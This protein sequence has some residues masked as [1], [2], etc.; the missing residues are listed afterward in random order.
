MKRIFF[1][2]KLTPQINYGEHF[3]KRQQTRTTTTTTTTTLTR[4]KRTTNLHHYTTFTKPGFIIFTPTLA[5]C[6]NNHRRRA[7]QS[8]EP[9]H[10]QRLWGGGALQQKP[11][12]AR[13]WCCCTRSIDLVIF[14]TWKTWNLWIEYIHP[15]ENWHFHWKRDHVFKRK[16]YFPTINFWMIWYVSFQ[17]GFIPICILWKDTPHPM[18]L[19]PT[20]TL[21]WFWCVYLTCPEDVNMYLVFFIY[22]YCVSMCGFV[23]TSKWLSG[24]PIH[25][26]CICSLFTRHRYLYIVV[27]LKCSLACSNN[28]QPQELYKA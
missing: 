4:T 25:M 6:W 8:F 20:Y 2:G 24:L 7:E 16:C 15:C 21:F 5:P 10:V 23:R 12:D 19:H 26:I 1:G 28:F 13:M 11:R 14:W 27:R 17:E 3:N 9:C 18:G 22:R